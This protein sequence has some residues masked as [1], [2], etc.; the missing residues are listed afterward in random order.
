MPFR[1]A[2]E[3]FYALS[4]R[5]YR[6]KNNRSCVTSLSDEMYNY[7]IFLP[8]DRDMRRSLVAS[9]LGSAKRQR[10][11]ALLATHQLYLRT[12]ISWGRSRTTFWP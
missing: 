1:G 9:S 11:V 8:V 4:I 12:P 10:L 5:F 6:Q 7:A 3:A 2:S